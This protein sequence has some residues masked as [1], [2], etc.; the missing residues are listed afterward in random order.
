MSVTCVVQARVGSS[1]LPGK[2][3]AEVGGQPMLALLLRR[4][5]PLRPDHMV[6]ATTT[7]RDDDAIEETAASVGVEVLRGPADDVLA[8]FG[9]VLD[10]FPASSVV[11]ITADCPFVDA[12]LVRAALAV[13]SA[14]DADYVSNTLVRTFPDG[15]DV[16][17]LAADALRA[18]DAE[19]DDPIEREHVT[20]FVYRR[21]ERFVLRSL[22]HSANLGHLRWTVDTSEDL[23]RVRQIAERIGRADFGWQEALSAVDD[24]PPTT[25]GL[26]FLAATPDDSAVVLGLRND[27][28]S[29]RWSRSGRAVDPGHHAEWFPTVL[30]DPG[31]RLWI[32]RDRGRPIGQVRIDVRDGVGTISLAVEARRR[33]QGVG[34]WML[35]QLEAA[36]GGDDQVHTLTADVHRDNEASR[37]LFR[38]AGF[39][40][41]GHDG[42]FAIMR[43]AR[44]GR[45]APR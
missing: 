30:E 17:V 4:L 32:A 41:A 10:Q 38:G 40:E 33:E 15:L 43:R 23:E 20:P 22:R 29:I 2:I 37:Q 3:L 6:V 7:S 13:R 18:A 28:L 42:E 27:P 36:L 35:S 16:E 14:T 44:P 11:R 45:S 8:R 39:T 19:A 26:S 5:A 24:P 9:R 21:P 25:G 31:S 12:G 1:R 34:S